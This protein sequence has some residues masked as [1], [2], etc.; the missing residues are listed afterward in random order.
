MIN[1]ILI[2]DDQTSILSG[3]SRALHKYCDFQGEITAVE[4][5]K[6]ALGAIGAGFYDICFLD[7]NLPDMS[8]LDV[9]DH[10]HAVSPKTKIVI[11]TAEF[12]DDDIQEKIAGG[13]FMFIPK[14]IELD[15]IKAFIDKE[16]SSNGDYEYTKEDDGKKNINEKRETE[17]RPDARTIG[18]SLSI[19][20]NWEL[21]SGL[22]ADII[23]LSAG[24][25][26]VITSYRLYP[27]N[28]LRFDS[29]LENKSGVV[30][31]SVQKENRYRAG[32]RFI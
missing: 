15:T 20:H 5:G 28:V 11:M 29:P 32:I 10:I 30:K 3:M 31:W 25:I 2:V 26:G 22:K 14:P 24:G 8:G 17:R 9:M 21:K 4:S 12:L 6:K 19:F 1:K 18:Y 23:D 13:A 7:L 16:S 27:G